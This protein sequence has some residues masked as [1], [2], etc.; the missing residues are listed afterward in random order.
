[1]KEEKPK[2][3]RVTPAKFSDAF[4]KEIVEE[5]LKSG[6]QK[7]FIEKKYGIRSHGSIAKWMNI[8]GYEDPSKKEV[9]LEL[10]NYLNLAKDPLKKPASSAELEAKIRVLEKQL[11]D[12]R[13]RAEMYARMIDLAEKTYKIPVR[14]NYNTK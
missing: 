7:T 13:L 12:E 5:Y 10:T 3:K 9:N 6:N 11:E 14:K 4:K 1:M 8:L 2:F